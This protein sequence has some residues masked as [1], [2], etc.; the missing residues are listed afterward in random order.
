MES[1]NIERVVEG[2]SKYLENPIDENNGKL[3]T[4]LKK[5]LVVRSY[6]PVS[7]KVMILFK[8]SVDADKPVNIPSPSYCFYYKYY[9]K[10]DK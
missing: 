4:E 6:I 9:Y 5:D 2:C 7:E 3:F 10:K 1:L 8:M